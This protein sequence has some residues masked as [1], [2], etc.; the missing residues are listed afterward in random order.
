MPIGVN[1]NTSTEYINLKKLHIL[2]T[3]SLATEIIV[4]VFKLFLGND[5]IKIN[6]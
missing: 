4:T 2:K 6:T 5:T 1:W 3:M